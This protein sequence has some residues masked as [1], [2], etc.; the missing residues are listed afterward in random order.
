MSLAF[1]HH[2]CFHFIPFQSF[3]CIASC[4]PVTVFI[5]VMCC[6]LEASILHQF[7]SY[8]GK[9]WTVHSWSHQLLP[10]R[11][12]QCRRTGKMHFQEAFAL[13]V[14][15]N[16]QPA[17][18]SS[19]WI[20]SVIYFILTRTHQC[21]LLENML[22]RIFLRCRAKQDKYMHCDSLNN[23]AAEIIIAIKPLFLFSHQLYHLIYSIIEC[24]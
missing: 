5:A 2:T 19:V 23:F 9:R 8:H 11:S 21:C 4:F 20:D 12:R 6:A 14:A 1:Q 13:T 22:Q 24:N 18:Y 7:S 15:K 17:S 10:S 3:A 16:T